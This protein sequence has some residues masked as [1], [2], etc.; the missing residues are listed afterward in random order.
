MTSTNPFSTFGR[1]SLNWTGLN[2]HGDFLIEPLMNQNLSQSDDFSHS[3]REIANSGIE[4]QFG[5]S[6]DDILYGLDGDDLILGLAGNDNLAGNQGNDALLGG[7]E[8]DWL[9]GGADN[10]WLL[11]NQGADQIVGGAQDDYLFGGQGQDTLNGQSGND[12]LWGEV[13]NDQLNGGTGQDILNGDDG[14]DVLIDPDGGGSL[15]GGSG[16]D[17]FRIGNGRLPDT[18]K[19]TI[20]PPVPDFNITDFTI[21]EDILTLNFGITFDDLMFL[22]TDQG[23]IISTPEREG[24][25]LLEGVS[26]QDLTEA[27]F[28]FEDAELTADFQAALDQ[29]LAERN[30]PG[31]SASVIMSDGTVWAGTQGVSDLENQTPLKPDD[32]FVIGSV[33]KLFTATVVMQLAEEGT[34][35]LD[36]PMNQ[37]IPGIAERIPNGD[38]I[39]VRQLVSHTSGVRDYDDSD[40][41]KAIETNPE[42]AQE[43]WTPEDFIELIYDKEPANSPGQFDYSNTNYT[44]LGEIIEAATDSDL[45]AQFQTRI[46]DPLG[47]ENTFYAL[48]EDI[49]GGYVKSYYDEDGDGN[50][51]PRRY[52]QSSS[53]LSL[54]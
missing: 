16:H 12:C 47:L 51:P 10:D 21:G 18:P 4:I 3:Q 11:G 1:D 40:L 30:F 13:G 6:G 32:R 34:L 26:S 15:T 39:T 7:Q 53:S 27:S 5:S 9:N 44:L 28:Q 46:F 42:R 22:D 29:V 8:N 37:W 25:V 35:N 36:D 2:S 17:E 19:I 50:A 14:E 43:E 23:T 20:F 41:G 45:E 38:Q 52:S 31:L 48:P 33:T 49:P 54:L 24:L